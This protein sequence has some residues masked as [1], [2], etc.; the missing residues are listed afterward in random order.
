MFAQRFFL[1]A[2]Q[3]EIF[4]IVYWVW[5]LSEVARHRWSRK[6]KVR[7]QA[8]R[9]SLVLI[10][11]SLFLGLG[12]AFAIAATR[13]GLLPRAFFSVGITM[14]LLGVAL[15]QWAIS[16]L[17]RHFAVTVRVLAN[18]HLVQSGPYR[19]IRH[20]AYAGSL[21]TLVGLGV[22]LRSWLAALAILL[23][24]TAAYSYR[25]RVEEALLAQELGEEYVAYRRRTKR[26]IPWLW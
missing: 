26:L 5:V 21:L 23:I 15:R 22:V 17:G 24:F 20:P 11:I 3:R 4:T 2:E 9:G 1:S 16:L 19:Y 7:A 25:I 6:E 13:A 12:L 10:Y 14:M 18:H 8:D